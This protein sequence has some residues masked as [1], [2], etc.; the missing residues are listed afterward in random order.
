MTEQ[1]SPVMLEVPCDYCGSEERETLLSGPD[2]LHHLPG[3]FTVVRCRSCGLIYT[4]PRPRAEDMGRYYP[5]DYSPHQK[6]MKR[7]ESRWRRTK[8]ALVRLILINFYGYPLGRR[9]AQPL[10]GALLPLAWIFRHRRRS[11][12]FIPW[13]GQG[14][15]LDFGCGAG[16]YIRQMA[17]LGWKV[18][19]L[20]LNSSAVEAARAAG[21]NVREGTLPGVK[22]VR[23]PSGEPAS[24]DAVTMW[25]AIEHIPSPKQTLPEVYR[26]LAPGGV[27][28][29]SLPIYDSLP[30]R[31]FGADWFSLDLPRHLTHFTRDT[32]IWYVKD[33]G[34]EIVLV[35]SYRRPSCWRKSYGYLAQHTG[36]WR[37]RALSRSRIVSGLMSHWARLLDSEGQAILLA[38]KPL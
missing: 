28:A 12:H 18:E 35:K 6:K 2:R 21:L 13:T 38:K 37:H 30:A 11:W 5:V 15:L 9:L 31:R 24:F 25:Q 32:L 1:A 4:S 29:I 20:D 10:R 27:L 36:R 7:K 26:L 23:D 19:G 34:F 22:L 17:A 14:R 33:A 16:G 3:R 8:K